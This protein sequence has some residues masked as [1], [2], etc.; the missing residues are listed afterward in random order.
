MEEKL[1]AQPRPGLTLFGARSEPGPQRAQR[2]TVLQQRLI[3]AWLLAFWLLGCMAGCVTLG[4]PVASWP[5]WD[6]PVKGEVCQVMA[7]WADGVVVQPDPM[8]DGTPTPGLAARIYLFGQNLDKPLI[9]D[10][11]LSIYLY[12][13]AE[14][15]ADQ[16]VLKEVW[17]IDPANL[18][19]VLSKDALGWGYNLWLPWRTY[20]PQT[21]H[22]RL[23]VKYQPHQGKAAW[24]SNTDLALGR[25]GA[26]PKG[27]SQLQTQTA[28]K[29]SFN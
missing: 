2:M 18:E 10:G 6:R 20:R 12:E 26:G 13:A 29:S 21:S 23:V 15:L 5:G 4:G 7:L 25:P 27:V 3:P 11:S 14:G 28:A 1:Q 17:N 8:N 19:R 16:A 9:A 24:S 22:V